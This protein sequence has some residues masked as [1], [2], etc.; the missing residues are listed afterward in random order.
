MKRNP[1]KVAWTKAYRK[2][3]GKEMVVDSTFEFEKKRNVPVKYNRDLVAKT[4]TAIKRVEEV[5][6]RRA[7]AFHDKR[8]LAA[9]KQQKEQALQELKTGIALVKPDMSKEFVK[10]SPAK[11]Q[12]ERRTTRNKKKS[13]AME[14]D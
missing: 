13:S 3:R 7:Q 10:P 14:T 1:R 2:S 8:M 11:V 12:A 4:I 9:K 6:A 5:K